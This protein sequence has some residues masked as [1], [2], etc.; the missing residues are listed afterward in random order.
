MA[1]IDTQQNYTEQE[2][3]DENRLT[4]EEAREQ[5]KDTQQQTGHGDKITQLEQRLD[6]EDRYVFTAQHT[7]NQDK[8]GLEIKDVIDTEDLDSDTLRDVYIT[9]YYTADEIEWEDVLSATK[10][11]KQQMKRIDELNQYLMVL[12]V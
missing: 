5:R 1:N 11:A 4:E 7:A 9:G 6:Q 10:S 8:I 2:R 3:S 12:E